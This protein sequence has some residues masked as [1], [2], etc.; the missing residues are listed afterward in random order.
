LYITGFG[1]YRAYINGCKVGDHEMVPGWTSY[2][3]RLAY[4]VF[5]VDSLID[6]KGNNVLSVEVAEGW[7][8]GRL[9]FGGGK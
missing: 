6:K 1:V 2:H 3:H 4:Q 8:A 9:G 5:E 7:Y